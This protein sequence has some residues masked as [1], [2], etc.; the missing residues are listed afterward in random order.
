MVK[1]AIDGHCAHEK[2]GI[3]SRLHPCSRVRSSLPFGMQH[4]GSESPLDGFTEAGVIIKM[5]VGSA[6]T[7]IS[8]TSKNTSWV[9]NPCAT[10]GSCG[11]ED[12]WWIYFL[13]GGGASVGEKLASVRKPVG[14]AER[15]KK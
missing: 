5:V 6:W 11:D 12:F 2:L 3:K 14:D 9:E 15:K 7:Q 1:L 10:F 13:Q 8:V 4:R